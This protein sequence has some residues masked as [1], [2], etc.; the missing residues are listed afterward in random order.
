[1]VVFPSV[2]RNMKAY[3]ITSFEDLLH[4]NLI[5]MIIFVLFHDIYHKQ[6]TSI[7]NP[8]SFRAKAWPVFP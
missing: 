8:S 2:K 1:M 3:K 7:S 5:G 6:V 4:S